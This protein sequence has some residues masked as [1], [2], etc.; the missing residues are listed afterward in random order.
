MADFDVRAFK[1]LLKQ[2]IETIAPDLRRNMALPRLA[3]VTAVKPA[4][5]T[6][7]CSLQPVLNDRRPDPD[8]PVI[9]DVEIP[10]IWAG[11]DRGL[12]C[13][14]KVDEYCVVGFYDGDPNSPFIINFRPSSA[15]AAELDSLM[16]QHSPG[17]RL[18]FKPDGTV[19]V[20]APNIEAKATGHIKAEAATAEVTVG[21][22]AEISAGAQVSI[23]APLVKID[24]H[25]KITGAISAEPGRGGSG[26]EVRGD[27]KIVQGGLE[28]QDDVISHSNMKA[29]GKVNAG[30]D[31]K[32][33]GEVMDGQGYTF[34]NHPCTL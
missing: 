1:R 9:P 19:L 33:G 28:S 6:Y 25:V 13:P 22:S 7:V 32:A 24:G 15:P 11:P 34:T 23:T 27:I 4:G 2:V 3:K 16:I 21:Q 17:V 14:P 29:D 10:I 12:V 26:F 5:G 8:A 30:G 18:G 31:V 20:E